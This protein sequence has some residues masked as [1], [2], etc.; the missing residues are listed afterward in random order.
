M[1]NMTSH[2]GN[3]NQNPKRYHLTPVKTVTLK[4]Q[5]LASLEKGEPSTHTVGSDIVTQP[6]RKREWRFLENLK[7]E[8]PHAPAA[9]LQEMQP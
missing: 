9:T 3:A 8:P 2:Q 7:L 4:R 6:V 1:L 5:A